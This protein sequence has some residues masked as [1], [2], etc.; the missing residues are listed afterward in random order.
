MRNMETKRILN[1]EIYC[2][3]S[4]MNFTYDC[5]TIEPSANLFR[6]PPC[7]AVR[8]SLLRARNFA[9]LPTPFWWKTATPDDQSI[10]PHQPQK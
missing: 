10:N 5:P 7:I 1:T 6:D 3:I 9:E 8:D 2:C 4:L